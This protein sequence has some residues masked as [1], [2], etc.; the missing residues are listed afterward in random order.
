MRDS[1]GFTLLEL[2]LALSILSVFVLITPIIKSTTLE[3]IR[4]QQ[5]LELF[6][7]DV[8]YLQTIT[9]TSNEHLRIQFF[10]DKYIL[11]RGTKAYI[12]RDYPP[13]WSIDTRGEDKLSFNKSGTVLKPRTIVFSNKEDNYHAIFPF[14]KGRFYILQR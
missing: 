5:F 10:Q 7:S 13:Q 4:G 14:G 12:S 2:L 6:Q 1:Y 9:A 3:K 11:Y 8:M